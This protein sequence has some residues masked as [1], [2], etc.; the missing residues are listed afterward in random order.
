ML[1]IMG[2]PTKEGKQKRKEGDTAKKKSL[3][4]FPGMEVIA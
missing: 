3:A 2:A 4:Y 1:Y